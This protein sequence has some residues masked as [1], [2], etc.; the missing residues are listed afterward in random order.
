M[1]EPPLLLPVSS[2]G[3]PWLKWF[4]LSVVAVLLLSNF[5]FVTL[6]TVALQAPLSLGFPRQEYCSRLPSSLPGDLSDPG[7]DPCLLH[8]QADSLPLSHQGSP[9]SGSIYPKSNNNF[10]RQV[11]LTPVLSEARS[12]LKS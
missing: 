6:R 4:L 10:A 7:I 1:G 3:S 2:A 8:W 12:Q 9:Q 5:F 11:N